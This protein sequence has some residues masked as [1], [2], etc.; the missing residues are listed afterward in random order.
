LLEKPNSLHASDEN[1]APK[2]DI[3]GRI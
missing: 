1:S 2:A 3:G